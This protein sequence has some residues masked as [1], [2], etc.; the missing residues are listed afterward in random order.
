M[1]IFKLITEYE[2]YKIRSQL[3]LSFCDVNIVN[4]DCRINE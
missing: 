4:V 3:E 2:G 1:G